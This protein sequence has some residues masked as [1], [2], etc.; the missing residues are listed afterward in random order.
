VPPVFADCTFYGIDSSKSFTTGF[1]LFALTLYET[2]IGVPA[3]RVPAYLSLFH[4]Y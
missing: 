1:A 3:V 2:S 4:R